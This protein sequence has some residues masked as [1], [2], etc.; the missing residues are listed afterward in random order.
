MV[1]Y[2]K[3]C[4]IQG[5]I[6]RWITHFGLSIVVTL[7]LLSGTMSIAQERAD[8]S[9]VVPGEDIRTLQLG[10]A[11]ERELAGG[12]V[13]FYEVALDSG[14]YL[15]VVVEQKG[16]DVVVR[17]FGPDGQQLVEVDSPTGTQGTE[18]I[19]VVAELSGTYRLEVRPFEKQATPGRYEV[20]MEG[21][22]E[23]TSQDRNRIAASIA[24]ER[25]YAEGQQLRRQGT[26]ESLYKAIEKYQE[27][28]TLWQAVGDSSR[29]AIALNYLGISY[30]FLGKL[31]IA[32]GYHRR[33][34]QLR[35]ALRDS[36][37][38]AQSLNNIGVIQLGLGEPHKAL[39]YDNQALNLRK[40]LGDKRGEANALNNIGTVYTN[41]G[42]PQKA[43][44]YHSKALQLR[45]SLDDVRGVAESLNNIGTCYKDLGENQKAMNHYAQ[46]LPLWQAVD[47]SRGEATTLNNIG[48][49]YSALGE[50]QKALDY[51]RKALALRKDTGDRYGEAQT[52]NNMGFIYKAMGE[53]Q[54]ALD[55]YFG[56]ALSIWRE[57]RNPLEESTTLN[58]IGLVH[59]SL[60]EKQIALDYLNQAVKL[61]RAVGD[62]RG[63]ARILSNMGSIYLDIGDKQKALQSL[64]QA[65]QLNRVFGDRRAEA[66]TLLTIARFERDRDNLIE[67]RTQIKAALDILE[68][69]RSSVISQQLRASYFAAVRRYHEFYIDLLIRLHQRNPSRGH[70]VAALEASERTRARSLLEILTE[71]GADIRQGVD[72]DLLE[73]ERILQQRLNAKEQ[74]RMRLL[75][76]K[77]TEEQK[78]AVKKQLRELLTQYQEV[79]AQIRATSPRYADLTQPQPLS[80]KEIQEQILDD[81]TMLLEYALGE[82]KSFLWVV[83][84]T[85]IT[86]LE[87]PKRTAIDSVAR[88]VYELL[89]TGNT[90]DRYQESIAMLSQMV[91]GPVADMLGKK[92][93]LI[94]SEGALQYIPFGALPVPTTEAKSKPERRPPLIVEHEIVS[95]PSASVLAVLRRELAAREP[96]PKMVAVLANPVFSSEDPRVKQSRNRTAKK[97]EKDTTDTEKENLIADRFD[98]SLIETGIIDG[99]AGL[100]RLIFTGS[101]AENIM[102]F[103]PEGKG[104]LAVNF[105]ASRATAM[106]PELSQYRI[107]HFATHALLNSQHPELSGIVLSLVDKDGQEQDGFLRLHDIYNLNLPAELI[108][109]SACQTAL[110]KE[111]KGE[112]LVGLTRGFMYAGAKRVV[113]SL[114]K[115][116][117]EATAELMKHFYQ[118]ILQKGLR[119]AEALR[120]AQVEMW[121]TKR[122]K[123]PYFWAA[124]V[125]QG[126]WR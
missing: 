125:L 43:L 87:L 113:A 86:S 111:I 49:F 93:L 1:R 94:V 26:A 107:V 84:P 104:L 24:A 70:N 96:A 118:G 31:Q 114:W 53:P 122:W 115:V 48:A 67:A 56:Q 32:L 8:S 92:R 16:V 27:A 30:D 102:S 2:C 73:R 6:L 60:G 57:I 47:N 44:D 91:L 90:R 61:R 97:A 79:E 74:Y 68:Y 36:A 5:A 99:R 123:S 121:K 14:Q 21:L 85:S 4:S 88:Q 65:L 98:R 106:S 58:N 42:D 120:A 52:L 101:E 116:E 18:P 9:A 103:V 13:H 51:Y 22:R 25:A 124:F 12:D 50:P 40:A 110:G 19:S 75:S 95:L 20:R 15:H 10:E 41:L 17:L 66:S 89:S 33:A 105:E 100:A 38:E 64:E 72:P 3:L 117:D 119:P 76:G 78:A 112:G 23:A 80:V 69:L 109:L 82:E 126:E 35:Q 7:L 77:H 55:D 28:L 46:A 39:Y 29:E 81:D 11:I 62:Q 63:E 45:R 59:N 108:V 34:L 54:K 37:G 83:T 71:A